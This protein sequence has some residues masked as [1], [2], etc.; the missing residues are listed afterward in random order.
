MLFQPPT[1]EVVTI[2]QKYLFTF[3]PGAAALAFIIFIFIFSFIIIKKYKNNRNMN[4]KKICQQFSKTDN[5]ELNTEDKFKLI[6]EKNANDVCI[7]VS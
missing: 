3:I 4:S 2:K 1:E 7:D 6:R 5:N